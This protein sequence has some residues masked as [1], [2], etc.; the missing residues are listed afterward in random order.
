M[1]T[2]EEHLSS[3]KINIKDF[4]EENKL[5]LLMQKN[6][7]TLSAF[8]TLA[9]RLKRA[10]ELTPNGYVD[11]DYDVYVSSEVNSALLEGAYT[12]L[13]NYNGNT[14]LQIN[15][16]QFYEFKGDTVINCFSMDEDTG[17][18]YIN[19]KE[20]CTF[21]CKNLKE[22]IEEAKAF[23]FAYI[24]DGLDEGTYDKENDMHILQS[25]SNVVSYIKHGHLFDVMSY[26]YFEDTQDGY[27]VV[28][29]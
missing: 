19:R 27:I 16:D 1:C 7:N 14:V 13:K 25:R 20:V 23:T 29:R 21:T 9:R 4:Y 22:F 5:L 12:I 28:N 3:I 6:I 8:R 17:K 18:N 26:Y 10:Y 24:S 15:E 11:V 2:L